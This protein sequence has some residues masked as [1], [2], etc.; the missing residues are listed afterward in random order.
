MSNSALLKS[1][2]AKKYW[3]AIT[4]L[5]LC[6]FLLI[7]LL[8]NLQLLL[9]D[10]GEAFNSYAYFMTHFLPIKIVSYVTYAGIIFH[11]VDGLLLVRQNKKARPV[12]YAYN[13][14]GANTAGNARMMGVLGSLVLVFIVTHMA[15]FWGQM[16]FG[17]IPEVMV[18]GNTEK[19][20]DLYSLVQ[21]TY[22]GD[23]AIW[24]VIFYV[25]S[26]VFLAV[27]LQHG[28]QSA[29]QSMGVN[30]K[31]YTPTIKKVG[32]AFSILIPLAFALIPILMFL[33]VSI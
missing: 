24:W 10:N 1:S 22:T 17:S 15:Q 32:T 28:F 23:M 16:H 2:L 5:F 12:K 8:G 27:H 19:V 33:G 20:K 4:G 18:P 6:L 11:A 29:F 26:Q 3:M 13:N 21:V 7:H 25:A 9:D 31:S 30:H 14:Q